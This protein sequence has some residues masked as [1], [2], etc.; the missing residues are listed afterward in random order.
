MSLEN[1]LL[2]LL[3]AMEKFQN[4]IY[5]DIVSQDVGVQ[6]LMKVKSEI[7]LECIKENILIPEYWDCE[8]EKDY[9]HPISERICVKCT[10]WND[11]QPDSR[12]NEVVEKLI[13]E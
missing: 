2:R 4:T 13:G 8:C 6:E 10:R 1:K 11:N 12:L 5:E 3:V 9:I 7:K